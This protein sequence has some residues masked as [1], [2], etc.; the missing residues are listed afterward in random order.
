M[1]HEPGRRQNKLLILGGILCFAMGAATVLVFDSLRESFR[2][3][4]RP[5]KTS[6]RADT[7]DLDSIPIQHLPQATPT[8]SRA[9]AFPALPGGSLGAGMKDAEDMMR[10]AQKLM[11]SVMN[12]FVD[13]QL[14]VP[15]IRGTGLDGISKREDSTHIYYDV[16]VEGLKKEDID[17]QV[18]DGQISVSGKIER[19]N[20][21]SSFHRTFPIPAGV[22]ETRAK[23]QPL[24]DKLVIE[25]PKK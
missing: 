22:D 14:T 13:D 23:I 6:R 17:I 20:F 1:N 25:F 12:D 9:G 11:D 24:P 21:F 8:D 2:Q 3:S 4:T 15:P 10:E 5:E 7:Q 16:P 19:E 18:S